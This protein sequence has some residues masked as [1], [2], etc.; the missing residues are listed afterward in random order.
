[1]RTSQLLFSGLA[2]AFAF[3][4]APTWAAGD[5]AR[6]V[7]VFRQCVACHSTAPGVHLTGPS[8]ANV[9]QHKAATVPGF[10][11]YSDALKKA[12]IVWNDETL[13]KWLANPDSLAPGTNMTFSGLKDPSV[14]ED[15]IAYLKSVADGNA[16]SAPQRGGGMMAEPTRPDL[17]RAPP[18]GQVVSIHHCEDSFAIK[19]ADGKTNKIWEFNLRFKTDSSTIG[20]QRGKPVVVGA[21]MQGDRASVVFASPGEI[22]G[23]VKESC[24]AF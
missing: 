19:T 4:I 10:V 23:F 12:N 20:P 2:T 1:M 5:A 14:R 6:G 7:G 13:S 3:P 17:K 21:G 15:V 9:W 16:P 24:D 22:S 11:R 8:L 18:P